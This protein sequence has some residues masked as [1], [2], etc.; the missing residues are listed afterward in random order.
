MSPEPLVDLMLDAVSELQQR[1]GRLTPHDWTLLAAAARSERTTRG[2]L[3]LEVTELAVVIGRGR[4]LDHMLNQLEAELLRLDGQMGAADRNGAADVLQAAVTALLMSD[5][6]G[7]SSF[8]QLLEPL[9][10][11][12]NARQLLT[13]P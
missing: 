7:E 11:T 8:D 12:A 5:V 13:A 1:L 4:L 9:V 2:V 6:I 3:L 10:Q